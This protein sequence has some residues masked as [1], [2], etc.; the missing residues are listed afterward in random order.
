[1]IDVPTITVPTARTQPVADPKPRKTPKF[2]KTIIKIFSVI[3]ILLAISAACLFFFIYIPGQKLYTQALSLKDGV[4]LLK[5][6]VSNKDLKDA[7]IQID[8]LNTKITLLNTSY[9]KFSYLNSLPYIRDYYADGIHTLNIGRLGLETGQIVIQ[10]V[11]PYQD[12]LGLKGSA[13]DSSKTTQDR[14][15]FLTQSV[16]GLVPHMDTI[17]EKLDQIETELNL[18]DP[19]RYPDLFLNIPLK[20][21]ILQAKETVSEIHQLVKNSTPILAKVPWLLGDDKPRNYFLIFQNDAELRPTGGFWTAYGSLTVDKG[22]ITPGL[23][24]NIYD[25]DALYNSTVPAPRPIKAYHINVP[26]FN[27]RDMNISPDFPTS[28]SQF[29]DIYYRITNTKTKFDA[30]IGIDTQVL[31]DLLKVLGRLGAGTLGNISADPDKRCNGCPEIIYQIEWEAGQ[32]RNYLD[33][34]RK[35]FLGPLIHTILSNALGAEKDKIGP[36]A[37]TAFNDIVEKHV[38]FFFTDPA[39]QQS[40]VT[41]NISGS[42][43][44]T[45]ANTDYLHLNDANMASAKT[46]LFLTQK[47]KHE[48]ITD[49]GK[50]EHKVTV[51]YTNPYPASNCN[52]EKGGLCLNAAKYRDWFRFYVPVNSQFIK[53]TGSE[54]D[55]VIYNE[56]GKEVFEGFYGNKYPLYAQSSAKTS[57]QYTSSV[58]ASKNYTLLLQKQPGTKT[59]PY[60]L[61]VNGKLEEKFDWTSDKTIKLS[62]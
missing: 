1:M 33:T 54:V 18:I 59:I 22:K 46:N 23:S 47:I 31:V 6:A 7:Q 55:P 30:V 28:I 29:M 41:A 57:V 8:N 15:T 24:G 56:L 50:V 27:L 44:Q 32:P 62:L 2:M 45:D 36:L 35:G 10:A 14:I 40:A 37:Q 60:E 5:T 52:L 38:L 26:Y 17:N 49:N 12:F 53:M 43:T 58:P 21:D 19:N 48:I 11:E 42:I 13:T 61:W 39:I 34:N 16:A 3:L 20:S 9:Q 4:S 51:T 25:L